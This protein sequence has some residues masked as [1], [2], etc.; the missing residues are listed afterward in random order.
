MKKIY[1][2]ISNGE[3]VAP[4]EYLPAFYAEVVGFI[5]KV[6]EIK[7]C[8]S[9]ANI[10]RNGEL[11]ALGELLKDREAW[12]TYGWLKKSLKKYVL[13]NILKPDGRDY[14]SELAPSFV[15]VPIRLEGVW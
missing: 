3:V 2:G 13:A 9:Q 10:D 6:V 4:S 1:F 15:Y 7:A 5:P 8:Y 11:W 12:A 14:E